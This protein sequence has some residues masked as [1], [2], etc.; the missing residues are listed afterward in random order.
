MI[1]ICGEIEWETTHFRRNFPVNALHHDALIL[2][3]LDENLF[4]VPQMEHLVIVLVA[5][6]RQF[7]ANAD[8]LL[9]FLRR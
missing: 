1:H 9:E 8:E 7:L 5:Q 4:L 6:R 3:V 2:D